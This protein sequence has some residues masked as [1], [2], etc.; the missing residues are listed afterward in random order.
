M[1]GTSKVGAGCGGKQHAAPQAQQ[2][3]GLS[4]GPQPSARM[5]VFRE[6][7]RQGCCLEMRPAEPKTDS[8]GKSLG[9]FLLFLKMAPG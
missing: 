4:L 7:G 8:K 2:A 5:R 6:A 1:V 3:L 9:F